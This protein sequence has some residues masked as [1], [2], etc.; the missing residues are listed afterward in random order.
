MIDILWTTL[1]GIG[2]GALF[3]A[4][5]GFLF[6]RIKAASQRAGQPSQQQ[7]D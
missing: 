7:P 1:Y 5:G 2:I 4:V 6:W 3:G